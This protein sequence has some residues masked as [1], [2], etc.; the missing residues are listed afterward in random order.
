MTQPIES[1][2]V[3]VTFDVSPTVT[4][5]GLHCAST[6][7]VCC[8][9]TGGGGGGG[10]GSGTGLPATPGCQ[11][12]RAC[13]PNFVPKLSSLSMPRSSRSSALADQSR[14]PP[15]KKPLAI[16]QVAPNIRVDCTGRF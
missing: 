1:C 10:G 5:H 9:A 3:A 15:R 6:V 7:S 8:G 12:I 4:V 14:P 16:C 11:P 2:A 13:Q